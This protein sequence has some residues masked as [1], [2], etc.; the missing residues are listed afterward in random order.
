MSKELIKPLLVFSILLLLMPTL[1][2]AAYELG[3]TVENFTLLDLDGNPVSLNDFEGDVIL[4]NFFA[5]WCPPCN[6]EAPVL[7]DNFWQEY[8]QAGFTVLAVDLLEPADLVSAW[9]DGLGLTYPT[10]L[11]PDWSIFN[12]FPGAGGIPYNAIIDQNMVLRSGQYG[13]DEENMR[14]LIES[15]LGFSPVPASSESLD[16]VKAVYR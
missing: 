13:F 16:A 4:L 6:D 7:E 11:S 14:S 1:A 5:T 3:D 8:Q 10:V 12:Q 2:S 15:L 9:V